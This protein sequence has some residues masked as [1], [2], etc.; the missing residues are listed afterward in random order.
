MFTSVP[1]EQEPDPLREAG[2]PCCRG[3][4][5]L[6]GAAGSSAPR[7]SAGCCSPLLFSTLC[8]SS[9]CQR[10]RNERRPPPTFQQRLR[11]DAGGL[12]VRTAPPPARRAA[13]GAGEG[14]RRGA[15]AGLCG[16]NLAVHRSQQQHQT[17]GPKDITGARRRHVRV[18]QHGRHCS[19]QRKRTSTLFCRSNR[20]GHTTRSLCMK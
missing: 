20:V 10:K 8:F 5:G 2:S 15:P 14:A 18:Q 4:A 16:H 1:C 3:N 9:A 17:H 7:S 13:A 6:P 19:Q 12:R 11:P